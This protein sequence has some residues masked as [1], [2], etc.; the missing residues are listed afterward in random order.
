MNLQQSVVIQERNYR[1]L[2]T[3]CETT[4]F[5]ASRS[6]KEREKLA[7]MNNAVCRGIQE[8]GEKKNN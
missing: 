2:E 3:F 5:K 4:T 7:K 1:E 6:Q 8:K